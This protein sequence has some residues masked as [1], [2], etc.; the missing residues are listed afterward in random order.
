MNATTRMKMQETAKEN[1][2][3]V[4]FIMNGLI[5]DGYTSERLQRLLNNATDYEKQHRGSRGNRNVIE[6]AKRLLS[7]P[8]LFQN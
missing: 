6:A 2:A 8:A 5:R 3:D 4:K 1:E 7:S